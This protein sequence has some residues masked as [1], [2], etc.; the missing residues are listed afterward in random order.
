MGPQA[1]LERSRDELALYRLLVENS[2]G[3]MCIHDCEGT[4]ISV[5]PAVA[6]SLGYQVH[7]GVGRNLR[8]FLVP[9]VRGLFDDYLQRILTKGEDSG[10]MRLLARDGS[11]RTWCYRNILHQEPG[12]P[13]LVLGHA[14]DITARIGAERELRAAQ[15]ELRKA[16]RE[17]AQRVAERTAELKQSNQLLRR[18]I[19]QRKEAEEQLLQARKLESLALLAGGI[20]HD[21]N[22][23]VAIIQGNIALA[24]T[25]LPE[26]DPVRDILEQTS[27]ACLRAAALSA[28]LL[29]FGKGG[30]PVRSLTAV[31]LVVRDAVELARAGADAAISVEIAADLQA[32]FLD[33]AQIG[34]ALQ[35][36]LLNAKQAMS[37]GG[38]IEVR[39]ANLPD[40]AS[41]SPGAQFIRISVQDYGCGIPGDVLPRIF[42]PYFTTR[43]GAAGLGLATAYGIVSKHGGRI[44]AQSTP[45]VGSIFCI[46]L[47][48]A[49]DAAPPGAGES[50]TVVPGTGRILVMDDEPAL[51]ALVA[52]S[53]GRMGYEVET[54]QDGAE[55][56]DRYEKAKA[57]GRAFDAVLLDLTVQGGMGG[58]Q[59][60]AKLR[61]IDP[62]ARLI[63]S[64]GYSDAPVMSAYREYG[65]MDV[66]P[67]PWTPAQLSRAV[68]RVLTEKDR[69][70]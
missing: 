68:H 67:K 20:A 52:R 24:K 61:E 51:R 57:A 5:N 14:L 41:P 60:A 13:A 31:D 16:H 3:L 25:H 34:Q 33:R 8:D 50:E 56:I 18:E 55:A 46:D 63:V 66:L 21:F 45:G 54:S 47:P 37:S 1:G 44:T 43:A 29:T 19:E 12:F 22:N 10:L 15:R 28:Q 27:G 7:E 38:I 32:A 4:L 11:E 64:S 35:N 6:N 69:V 48:A 40:E 9:A 53:L 2:L 49:E 26:G 58:I 59:A 62:E 65:F 42:D 39:A 30:S 70:G 23:F 17:L 36:L